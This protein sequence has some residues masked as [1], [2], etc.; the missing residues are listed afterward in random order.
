MGG[1]LSLPDPSRRRFIAGAAATVA[2]VAAGCSDD[3]GGGA[4]S[5]TGPSTTGGSA[6]STTLH[7]VQ[8]AGDPFGLGVA[9]G[10]PLID[11]VVLWTRLAP[12]PV[13]LDGL[14]AMPAEPVDVIW[15][16][17]ADDRFTSLVSSGVFTAEAEHAHSVHVDVTG[18]DPATDYH[19]RF[20]VGEFTSPT[21]RTRTLPDGSPSRFGLAVANCQWFE[22]GFY[23]AY[24]HMAE[25]D[26]D[27]VLHLGDYIYEFAGNPGGTGR[28][29]LPDHALASLTD[30]RLRYSSYRLD[31]DLQAAHARFPF[32]LT[33][34][35]HEVANNYAGDTVPGGSS[36][37]AVRELKAAA[38]KAWWEHLPVRIEP[39]EGADVVVRHDITV[40]DLARIYLLDERQ[41][42]DTPPCR[43][44]AGGDFGDCAD[45][46]GVDRS[47]LGS[48]QE[49]W[50]AE[51]S[52][53]GG[54]AWNVIG[55]PCCL[56]GIDGGDASAGSAYYLDSWD[57]F[58]SAQARFIGQ[59]AG[60]DNPVVLTGD[61]HQGMVL[62]VRER[63]FDQASA[64]VAT[65]FMAPPISSV[66]FGA[67]I[68]ARTPQLR[69][70]FNNHGYLTV[71]IEPERLTARFR[72]LANVGDAASPI[73]TGATWQVNPGDP[74]AQQV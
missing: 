14:G 43:D 68:S 28:T 1:H 3:G 58:P 35:D 45:R 67:D 29:T 44:T 40:G 49:A 69:Q 53:A 46:T 20:R 19:Y 10:D 25:E 65:E 61:Y 5:T 6:T 13:A 22:A 33:W 52:S 64:L 16:V 71:D 30:Y 48:E 12:D 73:A 34:D 63:P 7:T 60:I 15:E 72:I 51:T 17:A 31:A 4:S 74:N 42:S 11:A 47:L 39:P 56:A 36:P 9:S 66:L 57:G 62:E 32:A 27:L 50:F 18:L 55:N 21:G 41:D 37:E 70:Q 24:R 59:L 26:I 8:L 2:G 54:V 23:A 38:Y